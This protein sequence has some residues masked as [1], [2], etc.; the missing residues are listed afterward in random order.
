ML[1]LRPMMLAGLALVL[2]VGATRA[3][4]ADDLFE[5]S[6]LQEIRLLINSRDLATLRERYEENVYYPADLQWRNLRVRNV[7]VRSRGF[8]SRNPTKIGLAIDVDHYTSGQRFLGLSSLVLDNLWQDPAMIRE[9]LAMGFLA[10]MGEPAPREVF[11]RLYINNTYQGLYAVVED[12]DALFVS[13]TL[14]ETD[15]TLFEFHWRF[16]FF[17]DDLGDDLD[18]YKPLFEPRTREVDS[19]LALWGPIRDLWQAVNDPD[20]PVWRERVSRLVDL[21]QF[22]TQAAIE[23]YIAENDG[24][25][26]YAGMDNFYLYRS[27]GS[28]RHRMFAWDKDNAFLQG[29]FA[30]GRGV[31]DNKL[32]RRAMA[33]GDLR[34]RYFEVLASCAEVDLQ[35]SWLAR[36]ID[37][38][39]TL[40]T[41]A[42]LE[43]PRKPVS[44]E[45]FEGGV[46][47]LRAFAAT[48]AGYVLAQ[49]P[50][51][52]PT[53]QTK[54]SP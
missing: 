8:G 25:L 17:G 4:T 54:L 41:E 38:A 37:S 43:D 21:E 53:S 30:A 20:D 40:I 44:N 13:R 24:L 34:A 47:E 27:A 23:N 6:T 2:S 29:D 22:V 42:A 18:A 31:D 50:A 35:E 36:H 39:A 1:A 49:V 28:S 10:R 32:M 15:G 11:A 9:Y 5:S 45:R 12:I 19:D 52:M 16:P 48:R 46:A 51:A 26:G 33:E 7:G 3:Q 14:G